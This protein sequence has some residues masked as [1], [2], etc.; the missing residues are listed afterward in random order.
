V[1][2]KKVTSVSVHRIN[3]RSLK[4]SDVCSDKKVSLAFRTL[5]TVCAAQYCR[6]STGS[7]EAKHLS[8]YSKYTVQVNKVTKIKLALYYTV[9]LF[10]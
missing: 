2:K 7:C 6:A 10:W 5:F 3:S 9:L 4:K 1:H 8:K